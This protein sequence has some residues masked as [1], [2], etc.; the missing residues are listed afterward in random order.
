[1]YACNRH[2]YSLA[3]AHRHSHF[4][5]NCEKLM[6]FMGRYFLQG[7]SS[8]C[9]KNFLVS[10]IAICTVFTEVKKHIYLSTIKLTKIFPLHCQLK[11]AFSEIQSGHEFKWFPGQ[12]NRPLNG[13]PDRS[14]NYRPFFMV[15]NLLNSCP[16]SDLRKNWL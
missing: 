13:R 1:M 15:R 3:C 5:L 12:K 10:I 7:S 8:W 2:F 11:S 16:D 9:Q 14:A 4:P 6:S